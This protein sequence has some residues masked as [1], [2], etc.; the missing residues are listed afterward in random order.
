MEESLDRALKQLETFY[1]VEDDGREEIT[2]DDVAVYE[3]DPTAVEEPVEQAAP[4]QA[5]VEPETSVPEKTVQEACENL[6]FEG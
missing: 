2:L 1:S 5:A 4:E 3:Q 6:P